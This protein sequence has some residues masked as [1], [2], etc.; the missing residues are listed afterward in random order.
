[1]RTTSRRQ[2]LLILCVLSAS[3]L[4]LGICFRL[5]LNR[6]L[7]REQIDSLENT[8]EAAGTLVEAYPHF[9]RNSRDLRMNL[10]VAAATSGNDILLCDADGVVRLCAG[11]IQGCKH[12]NYQLTKSAMAQIYSGENDVSAALSYIY[13][14]ERMGV[15]R[16][17]YSAT[18]EGD[19]ILL[20]S[21]DSSH[22]MLLSAKALRI[23]IFTALGVL[24]ITVLTLP[25]LTRRETMP[26]QD[27]ATAA[28]RIAHGDLAVR[29]PTGHTNEEI[30]EL[31]VAFNNMAISLQNVETVRQEFVA[32]VS[33]ELK[34]PMTTISGYLDGMLDGTIP[35]E[36][37]A[38]YMEL[39]S[40]EVRRLSRLVRNML[41]V[42]RLRDQGIPQE[43]MTNFDIC[44]TA[45]QALLSFE[46][47]IN[48]KNLN[49]EVE[50]PEWGLLV[51]GAN[52]LITQVLYNL[53]DN[54][55]KFVNQ[56]GTLRIR[57]SQHG[58]RAIVTVGN[59]G[60]G[61]PGEELPLLFD[62]FHKTDKSRSTDRDGAGLGLYIVKTIIHAH[63]EDVYVSSTEGNTEFTFTLHTV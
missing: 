63:G 44:E 18:G 17:I 50:M 15:A 30:E 42:S 33:H 45:G 23:F 16:P 10:A 6:S 1:M 27:L 49:V 36:K 13:E 60:P 57:I 37:H 35:E 48:R 25:F 40:T 38:Y 31:S 52:D 54:A 28:R 26:I 24:L 21:K 2:L 47:R 4:L 19:G 56:A 61:I 11:H 46:Q 41:D 29:V 9:M 3:L 14:D 58:N 39:V 8:A 7:Y 12:T 22:A 32:N 43:K 51:H 53:I 20:V 34:T 55:V 59:T 62:R 5:F